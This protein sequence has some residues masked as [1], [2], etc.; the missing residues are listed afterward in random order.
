VTQYTCEITFNDDLSLV[1]SVPQAKMSASLDVL[2]PRTFILSLYF[3]LPKPF[4][5]CIF[6]FLVVI[7]SVVSIKKKKKIYF[8]NL[9]K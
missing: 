9:K 4:C 7:V 6:L 8:L 2:L 1:A 5:I 3:E